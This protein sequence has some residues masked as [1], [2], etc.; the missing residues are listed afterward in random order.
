MCI[1]NYQI[2]NKNTIVLV[3]KLEKMYPKNPDDPLGL[4]QKW[5][6]SSI[7]IPG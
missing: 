6:P 7:W 5:T 3:F 2:A 1:I 4:D